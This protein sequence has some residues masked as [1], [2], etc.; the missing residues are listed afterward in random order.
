MVAVTTEMI[1]SAVFGEDIE[2]VEDLTLT[3]RRLRVISALAPLT[4]LRELNLA[5]NSITSLQALSGLV[6]LQTLNVSYNRLESLDGLGALTN[7]AQLNVAHNRIRNISAISTCQSLQTLWLQH[8]ELRKTAALQPLQ[9]L[10]SVLHLWLAPNAVTQSMPEAAS[11]LLPVAL[12]PS[13]LTI[14]SRDVLPEERAAASLVADEGLLS[15][16]R[17]DAS[18]RN[19]GVDKGRRAQ[20]TLDRMQGTAEAPASSSSDAQAVGDQDKQP[21]FGRRASFGSASQPA[22]SRRKRPEGVAGDM[23]ISQIANMLPDLGQKLPP[24]G[25]AAGRSTQ[26]QNSAQPRGRREPNAPAK[27]PDPDAVRDSSYVKGSDQAVAPPVAAPAVEPRNSPGRA[28]PSERRRGLQ[29][30]TVNYP[31]NSAAVFIRGDGSARILWPNSDVAITCES[32]SLDGRRSFRLYAQYRVTGKLAAAFQPDGS[33]FVQFPHG[34]LFLMYNVDSG[35]GTVYDKRG[36]VMRKWSDRGAEG[37]DPLSAAQPVEEQLDE[38]LGVRVAPGDGPAGDDRPQVTMYFSCEG[39]KHTIV[40][41]PNA[42]AARGDRSPAVEERMEEVTSIASTMNDLDSAL[43]S[44]LSRL[45][46]S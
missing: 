18:P 3:N 24:K 36:D 1:Q 21:K 41:G 4:T 42:P 10:G 44:W 25:A 2:A 43:T 28:Q 16:Q 11:R 9:Y 27:A 20:G 37:F 30:Y 39:V 15:E 29:E 26:K 13:L 31:D 32:E 40:H 23:T 5:F 34:G 8:N 33:G 7:L 35:E 12:S 19:D 38:F 46:P 14:D 22:Q 6:H 17:A 45:K